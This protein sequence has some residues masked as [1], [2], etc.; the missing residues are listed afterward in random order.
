MLLPL[1]LLQSHSHATRNCTYERQNV[2]GVVDTN[3]LRDVGGCVV[4]GVAFCE[5]PNSVQLPTL[6]F[7]RLCAK[8]SNRMRRK[9]KLRIISTFEFGFCRPSLRYLSCVWNII[10]VVFPRRLYVLMIHREL[11]D[12]IAQLERDLRIADVNGS[13][14]VSN[15]GFE[16]ALLLNGG[17]IG[18]IEALIKQYGSEEHGEVHYARFLKNMKCLAS[19]SAG[20]SSITCGGGD[21][22]NSVASQQCQET[23]LASPCAGQA[24]PPL[25]RCPTPHR[26]PMDMVCCRERICDRCD[27]NILTSTPSGQNVCI[28][29]HKGAVCTYELCP[30]CA[31]PLPVEMREIVADRKCCVAKPTITDTPNTFTTSTW[32][33]SV[34]EGKGDKAKPM[35]FFSTTTAGCTDAVVVEPVQNNRA[36]LNQ[37]ERQKSLVEYG[38]TSCAVGAVEVVVSPDAWSAGS[39]RL[40]PLREV[41]LVISHEY[42]GEVTL[43]SVWE[44]FKCR[45][46]DVPFVELEILA[47]SLGLRASRTEVECCTSGTCVS[48]ARTLG[49]V[50]FCLLV[51][52]MRSTLIER[53]RR[54][55]LWGSVRTKLLSNQIPRIG[56]ANASVAAQKQIGND[57]RDPNTAGRTDGMHMEQPV[58]LD[59]CS[60]SLPAPSRSS[61]ASEAP[62]DCKQDGFP[63]ACLS[64]MAVESKATFE[65]TLGGSQKAKDGCG[66]SVAVASSVAEGV[67]PT[68][69]ANGESIATQGCWPSSSNLKFA[70]PRPESNGYVYTNVQQMHLQPTE[71]HFMTP[72]K[73]TSGSYSLY[74]CHSRCGCPN[75]ACHNLPQSELDLVAGG[76]Q[77]KECTD[78]LGNLVAGGRGLYNRCGSQ[79]TVGIRKYTSPDGNGQC[80]GAA[81]GCLASEGTPYTSC[82]SVPE[83]ASMQ[84][85][86]PTNPLRPPCEC[87]DHE[88]QQGAAGPRGDPEVAA[89]A[90]AAEEGTRISN[91]SAVCPTPDHCVHHTGG[92]NDEVASVAAPPAVVPPVVAPTV[93]TRVGPSTSSQPN[94]NRKEQRELVSATSGTRTCPVS[95]DEGVGQKSAKGPR[96]AS[97]DKKISPYSYLYKACSDS[98]TRGR[99]CAACDARHVPGP[100]TQS[101]APKGLRER[102]RATS[103]GP[104]QQPVTQP[105]LFK[106]GDQ[107][108]GKASPEPISKDALPK[109]RG[110]YPNLL[111]HCSRLDPTHSGCVSREQLREALHLAVPSLA[112]EEVEALVRASAE[113]GECEERCNYVS[114][115]NRLLDMEQTAQQNG[116]G[117][118]SDKRCDGMQGS[119]E[120]SA[121]VGGGTD[122]LTTG[123]VANGG[124]SRIHRLLQNELVNASGGDRQHLLNIFFAQ[125]DTRTGY[126]EESVFRKCLVQLFQRGRRELSTCLLDQYVRLCRTPFERKTVR[127]QTAPA[128]GKQAT[129]E[130]VSPP[131]SSEERAARQR[132]RSIPKPLWAV[133]CDYRYMIEELKV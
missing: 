60:S 62:G 19:G 39:D 21:M 81:L 1:S 17:S 50:D 98:G 2:E 66:T 26:C 124:R 35:S 75:L 106:E 74:C 41:F 24:V 113:G 94:G 72:V 104:V 46:I 10:A 68:A 36:S 84:L 95:R 86:V 6:F 31:H 92:E 20:P 11:A 14:F 103:I 116:Q 102:K 97:A 76:N 111:S 96:S 108:V 13:G 90:C 118:S 115:T 27:E 107:R 3:L 54:S 78:I 64:T 57:D 79:P 127:V 15:A 83:A 29:T 32:S 109:L 117:C 121:G 88:G 73:Q 120:S 25:K 77:S 70:P 16:K 56:V 4:N 58:A 53:I 47:D 130:I 12:S 42:C 45:G 9:L 133:L 69:C 34:M 37:G 48:G 128:C 8:G 132:V 85:Y 43:Q 87:D 105:K 63:P 89:S 82:R 18:H 51:A 5:A 119:I 65:R 44:A 7:P 52:R 67:E 99:S 55:S 91:H 49:V 123:N 61:P 112:A 28:E 40:I 93:E 101:S 125:D 71:G 23:G 30:N 38:K 114:L 129:H 126:L 122:K 131:S 33:C 100:S 59:A 110:R 22:P 80:D